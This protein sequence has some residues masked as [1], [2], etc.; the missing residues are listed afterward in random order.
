MV[1]HQTQKLISGTLNNTYL[2]SLDWNARLTDFRE[3]EWLQI[4][5]LI[6]ALRKQNGGTCLHWTT[7]DGV[8]PL[9][10]LIEQVLGSYEG[11]NHKLIKLKAWTVVLSTP[12]MNVLDSSWAFKCKRYPDGKKDFAAN[13]K[14][15]ISRYFY[16]RV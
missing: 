12:D 16:N 6:N 15:T 3:L 10:V 5:I 7:Q 8:K 11:R 13:V 14:T 2:Q 9:M 4:P 1:R